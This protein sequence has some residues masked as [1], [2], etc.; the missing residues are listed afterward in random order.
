MRALFI[1]LLCPIFIAAQVNPTFVSKADLYYTKLDASGD[2]LFG[3]EK[4]GKFGYIDKNEKVIIP[5]IYSY[6]YSYS[7]IPFFTKGYVKIKKDGKYGALDKTGKVAIPFDYESLYFLYYGNCASVSKNS[8]GKNVYGIVNMQ[9]KVIVPIEYEQFQIDSNLV[10]FKKNG[11]WGLMDIT[12]K[13][14]LTPEYDALTPYAKDKVVQAKKG[15][16]Y[17][18]IDLTGKWLFE[19]ASSVYL[20]YG[21]HYG[22]ISCV[23]SSK[24]G[25]LD[26]KGNE[27]IITRYDNAY[28]F[29][30]NG[31]A[32]V[33]N[34]K[35]GSYSTYQ[36]GF[37]DKT[38]K[39]VIPLIYDSIGT[40]NSG[41][42]YA[43]D[44]ET[45]RFG[46]LDKTGAW[47]IKPVYLKAENFD[48]FGGAWV[49]MTDAKYHYIN[50]TGKD[51]GS[52]NETGYRTFGKDGYA[53]LENT[54]YPYV[55][56]DKS[57]KQ[58]KKIEDCDGIYSFSNG[59]AGYKC[60][61]AGKYGF[62]DTDGNKITSCEYDGFDIYSD[63]LFKVNKK[64]DGKTKYGYIDNKGNI[65]IP[66]VYENAQNFRNG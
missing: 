10:A 24:Y 59:F 16:Q 9:N 3:F 4:D 48:D 37:A 28:N 46:Y 60:K 18:Y 36:Y 34:K 66:I 7:G 49:K 22:M 25:F 62:L 19:K 53:I 33:G 27:V 1:L 38:G 40:F 44:P 31:L 6:E 11:K 63:G 45:N 39:E 2:G 35:S 26:L 21:C 29:E 55:L 57:G 15:T 52:L 5:A 32:K 23:V 13:K 47:A 58:L 42:V 8:D 17:G 65:I 30:S 43:K 41:L 12:G 20:L 56:I 61:S 64:I 14:I 50:K 54:E 51:L